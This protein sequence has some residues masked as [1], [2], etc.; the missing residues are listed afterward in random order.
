MPFFLTNTPATFCTLMNE[1][2]HPY[3]DQFVVVYLYDIVIY[4]T[5]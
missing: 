1:I 5:P 4:A 3:W 2:F